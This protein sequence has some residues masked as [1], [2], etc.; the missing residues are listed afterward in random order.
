M[1]AAQRRHV[2]RLFGE[3]LAKLMSVEPNAGAGRAPVYG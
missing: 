2:A 1:A 3:K